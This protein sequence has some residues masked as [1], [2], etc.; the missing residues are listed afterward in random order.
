VRGTHESRAEEEIL[1]RVSGRRELRED[2]EVCASRARVAQRCE[3]RLAVS[4]EIPDDDVQL[5]ERDP[6]GFRLTVTNRV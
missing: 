5:R 3:D 2:D 6:Q 1:G 4:F